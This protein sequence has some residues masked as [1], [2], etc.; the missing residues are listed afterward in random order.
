MLIF[1]KRKFLFVP[2]PKTAGTLLRTV[3]DPFCL[4]RN[5]TLVRR[6]LWWLPQRVPND[7]IAS[8]AT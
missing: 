1:L 3:L 5:R 7:L 2:I 8:L 6:A 4:P